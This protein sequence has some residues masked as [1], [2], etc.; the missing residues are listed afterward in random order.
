MSPKPYR[1]P[2]FVC[3]STNA[4]SSA[5]TAMSSS[6]RSH[7]SGRWTLTA[8]G[9]PSRSAARCTWAS[10]AEANGVWSKLENA[11]EMR[12]PISASTIRS[13]SANPNGSVSSWR[14]ANASR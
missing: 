2:A 1:R 12:A 8:T 6:T 10:D 9:R 14:R 4:A 7:T 13:T 11:L 5:M 3:W